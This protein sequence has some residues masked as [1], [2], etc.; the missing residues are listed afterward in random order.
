MAAQAVAALKTQNQV[1]PAALEKAA[2]SVCPSPPPCR[3]QNAPLGRKG[4]SLSSCRPQA[5]WYTPHYLF[6]VQL[7]GVDPQK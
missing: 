1:L 3:F 5:F 6:N 4:V 2:V 7:P